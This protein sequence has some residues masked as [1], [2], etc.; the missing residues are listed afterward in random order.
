MP[1]KKCSENGWK[2]GDEGKCYTGR[3]AKKQAIKQ[4]IAIEGPKK[5]SQMAYDQGFELSEAEIEYVLE[6]GYQQ[7]MSFSDGMACGAMLALTDGF[8]EEINESNFYIPKDS[9]YLESDCNCDDDEEWDW[10]NNRPGLWENIRRKKLREGKNYKPAKTVKEGRPTQEQLKRAQSKELQRDVYDNPGEAMKRAKELGLDGIHDHPSKKDPEK[11]VYM[12]GKT[13]DA[14]EKKLREEM[15]KAEV[16]C[17]ADHA[18]ALQRGKPGPNDPRK[19][20]APKKDQK[21][22]SKKNKP[23]S[24]K[25]DKGKITF[26]Q[27]TID[28]LKS[29][30]AEH[31]KKGKGSKASLGAL[32]AVYRRGAGAYSTSHAPK[33]SRD[34]WAM[35]RVNA[36]LYLLRNGRPSNPNYKQ[37]NDLLP[38]SHPRSSKAAM[39]EKQKEA[40]DKNKDGKITKED[41]ELLRKTKGSY[42]Y[43]DPFT[44]ETYY[45]ERRGVYT[46]N[47]RR[48]VRAE[49]HSEGYGLPKKIVEKE[50]KKQHADWH[51]PGASPPSKFKAKKK[52]DEKEHTSFV[53]K[54][55]VTA[56]PT[57]TWQDAAVKDGKKVKL[58][59][60]FRTPDGPK[61]FSVY[62]KNEK[63]NVVK[64]N[65]GDPNMEIKRD[66]P[67]RRKSFRARH[68]CSNP[69]PKWKA[70]YWSCWQW[71]A[72]SPV[73]G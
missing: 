42:A 7:G 4:G 35:A 15:S 51:K 73:K 5:F 46:K 67:K 59:K 18:E 39:T 23:D 56:P 28:R 14:Y 50:L 25:D 31:N 26:S 62:V 38:S 63:G 21:K 16:E 17:Y 64:V 20:P 36:F 13:H 8:T 24:A 71:R 66:D 58:N 45:F 53:R 29:K 12:P 6:C 19:T 33:M 10:A 1:L 68:N 22:G 70:R 34:G 30:M 69:G 55:Q 60:P 47:G 52:K 41:F 2:W 27:K 48:L 3:D 49:E 65:F 32:K 72:S 54:N 9:E 57:M 11:K 44:G 40:L 43:K 61:K 37:D